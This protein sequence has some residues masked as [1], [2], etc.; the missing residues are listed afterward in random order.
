MAFEPD[1]DPDPDSKPF[2]DPTPDIILFFLIHNGL[3]TR[4]TFV[5]L[6]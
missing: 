4:I 5:L 2:Q 1:I 6:F 3:V